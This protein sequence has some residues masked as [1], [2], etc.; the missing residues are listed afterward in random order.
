MRA[1]LRK[2]TI[3]D[4]RREARELERAVS[5]GDIA[6]LRAARARA[7]IAPRSA[8]RPLVVEMWRH[9]RG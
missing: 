2:F 7:G 9:I 3:G 5:E 1:T 8:R 6:T 4:A